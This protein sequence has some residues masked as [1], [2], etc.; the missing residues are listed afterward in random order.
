MRG[1]ANFRIYTMTSTYQDVSPTEEAILLRWRESL[2]V[3]KAFGYVKQLLH[4]YSYTFVV[5]KRDYC[6]PQRNN[7]GSTCSLL[8]T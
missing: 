3:T 1:T 6:G 7:Q 2:Q 5:T 8:D 4:C